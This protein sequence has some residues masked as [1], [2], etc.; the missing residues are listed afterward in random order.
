VP[1]ADD[2]ERWNA[3][4]NP[5]RQQRLLKILGPRAEP[6][7]WDADWRTKW[8]NKLDAAKTVGEMTSVESMRLTPNVLL[9]KVPK[10]ATGVIAVAPYN[11]AKDLCDRVGVRPN[12]PG[13]AGMLAAVIGV[14][15]RRLATRRSRFVGR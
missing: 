15:V 5:E 8:Q 10:S 9:E 2:L 14:G 12:Q 7:V 11:S 13:A 1:A 4:W 3:N 6:V